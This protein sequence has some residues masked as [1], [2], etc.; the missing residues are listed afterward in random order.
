VQLGNDV[1]WRLA[2]EVRE[3]GH[4]GLSNLEG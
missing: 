3:A 4:E 1:V 2:D